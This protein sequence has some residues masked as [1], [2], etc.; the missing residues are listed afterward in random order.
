MS[1]SKIYMIISLIVGVLSGGAAYFLSDYIGHHGG[2]IQQ[3]NTASHLTILCAVAFIA[4][5]VFFVK[6]RN[7]K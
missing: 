4:A 7:D 5:I 6:M 3:Q 1:N 2:S